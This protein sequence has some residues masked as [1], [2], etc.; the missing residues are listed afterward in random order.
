MI[1]DEKLNALCEVIAKECDARIAKDNQLNLE[2]VA[3]WLL[4]HH[5]Q[6]VLEALMDLV[7]QLAARWNEWQVVCNQSLDAGFFIYRRRAEESAATVETMERAEEFLHPV[8]DSHP[9]M[10]DEDFL[11]F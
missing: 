1:W 11:P 5:R 8:L 2:D 3:E 9:D 7:Y 6:A 4:D 10:T